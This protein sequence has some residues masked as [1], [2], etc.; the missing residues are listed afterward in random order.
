MD[1]FD[2]EE[3]KEQI[4]EALKDGE[5]WLSGNQEASADEIKAKQQDIEPWRTC[6]ASELPRKGLV[7][8]LSRST[9]V[10]LVDPT[11]KRRTM[12]CELL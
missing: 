7:L 4:A 6:K 1:A 5:A 9:T 11:T 12:S 3:E 2:A 10:E 8:P